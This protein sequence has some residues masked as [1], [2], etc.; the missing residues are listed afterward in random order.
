MKMLIRRDVRASLRRGRREVLMSGARSGLL[1][2]LSGGVVAFFVRLGLKYRDYRRAEWR[3]RVWEGLGVEKWK[4]CAGVR[5]RITGEVEHS[6]IQSDRERKLL[7]YG[8]GLKSRGFL[9]FAKSE[10]NIDVICVFN[11][12]DIL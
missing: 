7:M 5:A 9:H 2:S 10:F 4:G 12:L 11:I 6:R 8:G 1:A 3:C